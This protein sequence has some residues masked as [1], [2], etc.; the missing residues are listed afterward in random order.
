MERPFGNP[1][2]ESTIDLPL[3]R[4]PCC[5]QQG[6]PAGELYAD[7]VAA[8]DVTIQQRDTAAESNDPGGTVWND[9]CD[10]IDVLCQGLRP[11]FQILA[12]RRGAV[13]GL[14]TARIPKCATGTLDSSFGNPRP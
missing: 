1:S 12:Q 9:F 3:L 13:E 8:S 2:L 7:A 11:G 5:K 6:H 4:N 14:T 10:W